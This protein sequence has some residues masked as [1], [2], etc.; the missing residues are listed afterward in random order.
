MHFFFQLY[1]DLN[2]QKTV[3]SSFLDALTSGE[4]ASSGKSKSDLAYQRS[5]SSVVALSNNSCTPQAGVLHHSS[6]HRITTSQRL[7]T[8]IGV[9]HQLIKQPFNLPLQNRDCGLP[10]S[11]D[12]G[13]TSVQSNRL[14]TCTIATFN[15]LRT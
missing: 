12:A 8:V 7:S 3:L 5:A 14:G 6:F 11:T 9:A 15:M 2:C 4:I 10:I 1:Q 13:S